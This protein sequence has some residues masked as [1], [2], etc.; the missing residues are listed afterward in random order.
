M[1][2]IDDFLAD[3]RFECTENDA[4]RIFEQKIKKYRIDKVKIGN[5]YKKPCSKTIIRIKETPSYKLLNHLISEKEYEDYCI[6]NTYKYERH[7]IESFDNLCKKMNKYEYSLKKGAIVIDQFN[8]IQDGQHRVSYL[9]SK[10]GDDYIVDV[11]RVYTKGFILNLKIIICFIL[12]K[13][14]GLI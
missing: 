6:N 3:D 10:Y 7:S 9:L 1:T 12:S 5:I 2:S 14:R 11:V 13:I 4:K 8:L